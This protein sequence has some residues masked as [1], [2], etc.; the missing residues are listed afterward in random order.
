MCRLSILL[1]L[2]FYSAV[3]LASD[4]FVQVRNI[5]F[6]L[7]QSETP[8]AEDAAWRTITLPDRWHEDKRWEQAWTGWYRYKLPDA[9][10][11]RTQAVYLQR[12]S[13]NALVYLNNEFVGSGGSF[14]EPVARNMHR[15]LFFVLPT[16]AWRSDSANYLYIRLRV[17][18]AFAHLVAMQVGDYQTLLP[19]YERQVFI[20]TTL[21]Q[22]FFIIAFLTGL[23]GISFWL[24]VERNSTNLFF[25]LTAFSWSFYCVNLFLRDIPINAR[26][27]W[28]LIHTNIEWVAVFFV[29]FGHR[30]A[31]IRR[32]WL[33]YGLIAYTTVASVI[34][35]VIDFDQINTVSSKLHMLTLAAIAYLNLWLFYLYWR[36]RN[37]D[38]LVLGLC[39]IG[40]LGLGI[41]DLI[42]HSVPVVSDQWQTRFY[43]LQFG[44][45]IMFII[46]ASYLISR[47]ATAQKQLLESRHQEEL[48]EVRER[49]RIYQDLH[50][51]VGAK[52]LSLVYGAQTEQEAALA[53]DA[54]ADI[55]EIVANKPHETADLESFL[56][57]QGNE[58][59]SRC[60]TANLR[61]D[62][63]IHVTEPARISGEQ[64]YNISKI[65]REC[66]SNTIRH[67]GATGVRFQADYQHA[68]LVLEFA[69]NGCGLPAQPTPGRGL[70]GLQRRA[71]KLG[72]RLQSRAGPTGGLSHR[73][74]LD[75]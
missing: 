28:W 66:L 32:P 9:P 26:T 44:A 38:A 48:A 12:L 51:D 16:T 14:D 69:D 1:C 31:G 70:G 6:S 33:E 4:A 7:A 35:A 61:Y 27:W 46:L 40:V 72:A 18:P 57:E 22:I 54:L 64:A 30:F 49:E 39:V 3:S 23:F 71:D 2:L 10:P 58:M 41:N 68:Q 13:T 52:L 36:E 53:R 60:Q 59:E 67:S 15:P 24:L 43:L 55:R 19:R 5:D 29:V 50:D 62:S 25:A 73:L 45:P 20:Q 63:R 17:Y 21:S 8:P 11:A 42:R 47:Y 75:L 65:L 74:Q 37:R 56:N 34:Y